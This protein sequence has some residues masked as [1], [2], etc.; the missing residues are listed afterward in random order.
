MKNI[1]YTFLLLL[2]AGTTISQESKHD[3][4]QKFNCP[5]KLAWSPL[6]KYVKELH[7]KS[8]H[9]KAYPFDY[10]WEDIGI[11]YVYSPSFGHWDIV[12]EV[13]DALVYDRKHALEQ[14]YNDIK[15]QE[16]NG[17]VPGTIWM[18][19]GRSGR[20]AVSWNKEDAGHPPLWVIAV[21][22][23]IQMGNNDSI[24][25][26][27]YPALIR[28]ITWFENKRK[29]DSEGFFYNDILLKK[30]ESGIDEGIRF[31]KTGLGKWACIDATSHVYMM[32]KNAEKWSH[33]L[34]MDARHFA[35][36]KNELEHFI[37]DSLYCTQDK[38]YRDIWAVKDPSL[39]NL[40]FEIF[41]PLMVG[42]I[43]KERADYLIDNY[44]LNPAHFL[45]AHPIP[46][47][48]LSDPKFELRLWRGSTWNSMTY[49]VARACAN[50]NRPDAAKILLERALDQT[51]RIFAETGTVWEFYH[52]MGGLQTDMKRK[53]QTPYNIPSKEYLGH[54]P[55]IAMADLYDQIIKME[56]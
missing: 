23:Y 36:R 12:H 13:L 43:P 42:A 1:L 28:Q 33:L 26:T 14:L 11:G 10:D 17:L 51:A 6:L 4:T 50:Y 39:R 54:N 52:P 20:V 18:P 40:S 8:T 44:L 45:T 34:G 2:I 46:T 24:L 56:K 35:K 7:E 37:N 15:N 9:P 25:K 53:P 27:A 22:D 21:D 31:D 49:W 47:V 41:W 38:V 30:W 16:P 19:G 48:S 5:G 55:L 32:Y 29:A 3:P